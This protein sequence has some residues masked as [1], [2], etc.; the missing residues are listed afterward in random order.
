MDKNITKSNS[1][2]STDPIF[3]YMFKKFLQQVKKDKIIEQVRARRYYSKPSEI[4]RLAQK[5]RNR[6][7]R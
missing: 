5:A 6:N 1:E 2:E 4:K 3:D 7:A